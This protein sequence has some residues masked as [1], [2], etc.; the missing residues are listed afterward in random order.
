VK[1]IE[2]M[3]TSARPPQLPDAPSTLD[4]PSLVKKRKD[5]SI[6]FTP[7]TVAIDLQPETSTVYIKVAV[8]VTIVSLCLVLFFTLFD[9]A[10]H[11]GVDGTVDSFSFSQSAL[12]HRFK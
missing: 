10:V 5:V 3:T 12:L 1:Q 9:V 7:V 11:Y 2:S 6:S 8:M 4:T